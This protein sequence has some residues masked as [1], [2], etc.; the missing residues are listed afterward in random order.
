MR[1]RGYSPWEHLQKQD[2]CYLFAF[3]KVAGTQIL[4]EKLK[5]Q[6]AGRSFSWCIKER[7]EKP[8]TIQ[9]LG[10]GRNPHTNPLRSIDPS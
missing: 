9:P 8:T 5:A 10:A 4:P 6:F 1:E 7:E 3:S 2:S